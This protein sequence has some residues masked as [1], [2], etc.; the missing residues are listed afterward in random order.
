MLQRSPTYIVA[1]PGQDRIANALKKVLPVRVSYALARWKNILRQM[2]FFNVSR[3]WP[4]AMKAIIRKSQEHELGR[5]YELETHLAPRYDPWDERLCIAPDG[6]FFQAIRDGKAEIVTDHIDAFTQNGIRLASGRELE[7]DI[8]VT[9]TGLD[10]EILSGVT[11]V[12]DGGEVDLSR[13][14][15]YKGMMYSD[16]P[17]LASTFGYTNASWTLKADL[18]AEHVCRILAHMDRGG[19]DRVTPRAGDPS[20]QREP[21]LDLTSGYVKRALG[22]LPRQGSRTPWKLHQNYVRD[23][24]ALRYGKVDDPAL[25]FAKVSRPAAAPSVS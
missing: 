19:F 12:V 24:L 3:R 15:T 21:A 4:G 10:V 22:S 11:L 6:D 14:L 17:N 7:A 1:Q 2:F 5:G 25:E 9:A 16:V 18:V 8:I 20:I 13:T 23:L